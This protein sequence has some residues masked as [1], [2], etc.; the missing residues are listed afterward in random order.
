MA[1]IWDIVGNV[2]QQGVSGL[3]GSVGTLAKD[4]RT[5]ITGTAPLTEDMRKVLLEEAAAAEKAANDLQAQMVTGQIDLNKLDAGSTS[6]FRSYPRP[7]IMWICGV[8]LGYQYLLCPVLSWA[9]LN[10]K[11]IAPPS[12]DMATLMPL[13][14]ALLGLGTMRTVEKVNGL[15]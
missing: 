5:A 14:F 6:K 1:G 13:L 8:A 9:S 10:F 7:F 4:L 12:L 15:K 11:W 2:V 3:L